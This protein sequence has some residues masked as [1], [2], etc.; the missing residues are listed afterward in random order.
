MSL[1]VPNIAVWGRPTSAQL[2]VTILKR[3]MVHPTQVDSPWSYSSSTF[4][5]LQPSMSCYLYWKWALRRVRLRFLLEAVWL[6]VAPSTIWCQAVGLRIYCRYCALLILASRPAPGTVTAHKHLSPVSS[7][8][9]CRQEEQVARVTLYSH[10]RELW[11][12][13]QKKQSWP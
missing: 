12:Y 1:A 5:A 2:V 9:L 6:C 11:V 13:F 8:C 4:L 10:A 7:R 3:L